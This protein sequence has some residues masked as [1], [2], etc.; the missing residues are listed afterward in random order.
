MPIRPLLRLP[1]LIRCAAAAVQRRR[2][3]AA[4]ARTPKGSFHPGVQ[5]PPC[6]SRPRGRPIEL[7]DDP[8]QPGA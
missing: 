7:R 3:I 6:G 8:E 5:P 4:I 1:L 2:A